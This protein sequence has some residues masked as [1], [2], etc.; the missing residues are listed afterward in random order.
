[1][2]LSWRKVSEWENKIWQSLVPTMCVYPHYARTRIK[3]NISYII[4]HPFCA[5]ELIWAKCALLQ[6][7]DG[8]I[9][10]WAVHRDA[11][12]LKI[13]TKKLQC[14]TVRYFEMR[15]ISM[16][17]SCIYVCMYV[18]VCLHVLKRT[19]FRQNG[20]YMIYDKGYIWLM[21]YNI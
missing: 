15:S 11:S 12:H 3:L 17:R 4:C 18:Y 2:T 21:L 8:Y 19:K 20:W 9:H 16:N 14:W 1:M 13:V 7:L 10:T 6:K 5:L